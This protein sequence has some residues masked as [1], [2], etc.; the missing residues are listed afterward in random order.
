MNKPDKHGWE[1]CSIL[2]LFIKYYKV[3]TDFLKFLK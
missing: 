2:K 1:S 3:L